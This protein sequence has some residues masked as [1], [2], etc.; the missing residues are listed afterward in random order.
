MQ[1][2]LH[3]MRSN[4]PQPAQLLVSGSSADAYGAYGAYGAATHDTALRGLDPKARS[5]FLGDSGQGVTTPEFERVRNRNWN[6]QLAASVCAA[7]A[8]QM[9]DTKV[10][11]KVVASFPTDRFGQ[12]TSI[13]DATQTAFFAQMQSSQPCHAW[14][15]TMGRERLSRQAS[16]NF[17]SYVAQGKTHTILGRRCSSPNSPRACPLRPGWVPF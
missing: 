17:R 15:N 3:W 13:H 10:V 12:F 2:I 11:A 16:P 6:Y 7:E 5:V 1:V 14:T 4:V 9:P 8:Q